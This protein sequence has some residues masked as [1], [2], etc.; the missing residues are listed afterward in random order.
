MRKKQFKEIF[1]LTAVLVFFMNTGSTAFANPIGFAPF[2]R[3]SLFDAIQPFCDCPC[4]RILAHYRFDPQKKKK[5]ICSL[6]TTAKG[7]NHE[8]KMGAYPL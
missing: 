3:C 7:G 6:Y 5:M 1:S 2:Y 8:Q 4:S